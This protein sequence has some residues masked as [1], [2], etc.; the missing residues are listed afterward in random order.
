MGAPPPE[1]PLHGRAPDRGVARR[2]AFL[3]AAR[4]VFLNQGYEAASVNDVV[5]IAGGS[6]ATLY[7]QFGNKE[8]LFLAVVQDQHERVLDVMNVDRVDHLPLDQGLQV[9]GE[10]FLH[11]ILARDSLN[12]FRLV[13]GEGRKF[14]ELVQSYI[15]VGADKV[16]EVVRNFI[17]SA[18]PDYK[19]DIE[20]AASY[21][22]ELVRSTHQYH[23]LA[24]DK[25]VL[26]DPELTAH[27][28]LAV[29]FFI[30]GMGCTR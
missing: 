18:A 30:K 10:Q 16:R 1:L 4:E 29:D 11:A 15:L 19:G 2:A 26:P 12:F 17:K 8:G 3:M 22:L 9:I 14:P 5:R 6:L 20:A 28:R 7:A 21:F 27:V 24:D 25:Y 13:V 23:A